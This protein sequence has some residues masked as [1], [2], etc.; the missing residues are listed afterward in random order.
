MTNKDGW[1]IPL[2]ATAWFGIGTGAGGI[3]A[4]L[5]RWLLR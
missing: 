5:L 4:L 3:G 2:P 1:E